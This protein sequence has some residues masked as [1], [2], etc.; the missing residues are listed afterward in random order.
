MIEILLNWLSFFLGIFSYLGKIIKFISP[1]NYY[2]ISFKRKM[3]SIIEGFQNCLDSTKSCSL[4]YIIN[5]MDKKDIPEKT[6]IEL[7]WQCK[8]V[9]LL[10]KRLGFFKRSIN[11]LDIGYLPEIFY[12]FAYILWETHDIFKSFHTSIEN[13]T[14]IIKELKADDSGYPTFKKIYDKT[15]SSFENLCDEAFVKLKKEIKTHKFTGL[16]EF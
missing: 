1:R 14:D 9:S 16:P 3:K 11:H 15:T 13:Q 5:K 7:Q 2:R 10:E 6:R 12:E 8:I 4:I